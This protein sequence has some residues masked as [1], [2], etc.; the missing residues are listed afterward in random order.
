MNLKHNYLYLLV[1]LG[2]AI[3]ANTN[4]SFILEYSTSN[5]THIDFSIGEFNLSDN[6]GYTK[7][8]IPGG[9]GIISEK[10]MPEVP[11]ITTMCGTKADKDYEVSVEIV[12]SYT[13]DDINLIPFQGKSYNSEQFH[14]NEEFYKSDTQYPE[15]I[16]IT[17]NPKTFREM[18]VIS[19]GIAPFSYNPTTKVLE[20]YEEIKIIISETDKTDPIQI[21]NRP[22]SKVFTK[23]LNG[24]SINQL[25]RE[26]DEEFQEPAILYIGNNDIIDNIYFQLLKDWRHKSGYTVYTESTENIGSTTEDIKNYISDAYETF[27]PPPEYVCF[28]GDTGGSFD[29]PTYYEEFG[30]NDYDNWC[31]GDQPYSLLQGNDM[32]PEV[33]LGRISIRSIT[34]LAVI[35]SKIINYEKATDFNQNIEYYNR[36]ALVADPQESGMSTIITNEYI[37]EIMGNNGLTDINTNYDD[38]NYQ[39]WMTNQ[40]SNGVLYFNYRGFYGV[41]GFTN[42]NIDDANNGFKLPL[43]TVLTCGTGSFAEDYTCLS[44]KFLRAGTPTN[45]KGAVASVATATSNT[46]TMFNN[47]INMGIYDGIF[48]KNLNTAGAS[49]VNG[50]LSLFNT[51]PHDPNNWVSAFSHWNTLMGDPATSLWK[52]TPLKLFTDHN[53]TISLGS[54]YFEIIVVDDNGQP[55]ENARV[56]LLKGDDE[57]FLNIYTNSQGI[58]QTQLEYETIGTISVTVTKPNFQPYE[59]EVTINSPSK[60]IN[61]DEES[62]IIILDND[63]GILNPNETANIQISLYN[64]GTEPVD[65]VFGTISS[66][67][68]FLTITQAVASY[69]TIE[70]GETITKSDYTITVSESATELDN[71]DIQL[72]ITDDGGNEWFANIPLTIDGC[73]LVVNNSG[74]IERNQTT[75]LSINLLNRGSILSAPITAEILYSNELLTISNNT[76]HW[77]EIAPNHFLESEDTIT[78]TASSDIINGTVITIPLRITDSNGYNQIMYYSLQVGAVTEVDPL[79]PD[80]YGYYIYDSEDTDYMLSPVYDWIEINP[81]YGGDGESL[82]MTD[83]GNGCAS[84]WCS[85]FPES[86]HFDLPFPFVFYGEEYNEITISTNGWISFG[87]SEMESFRN[88]PVPG[89]GGPPAMIAAF[90]DDL[91]TIS[92]DGTSEGNVFVYADP[93]NELVVIEWSDMKT[94]NYDHW[95]NFEIILYNNSNELLDDGDIKIQYKTVNNTSSGGYELDPPI[96]GGYCTVGIENHLGEY[97]LQYTYNNIYPQAAKTLSDEMALLITTQSPDISTIAIPQLTPEILH[98]TLEQNDS[99]E[100]QIEL[101]NAGGYGSMLNY[102]TDIYYPSTFDEVGGGP[103]ESNYFWSDSDIGSDIEFQWEDILDTGTEVTFSHNDIATEPINI[104]FEF[105]FYGRNYTECIINP[106]GWIG[107][108]EDWVDWQNYDLPRL[109]APKPAIFGFWDDLNPTNQE[110]ANGSGSVFYHS[111]ENRFVVWYKDVI[112]Y[113]YDENN[114]YDFQ[115]VLYPSGKISLNYNEMQ[116]STTSATIGIQNET[117]VIGLPVIYNDEYLQDNM[118]IKFENTTPVIDWLTFFEAEEIYS[119]E[120]SAE[121]SQSLPFQINTTGLSVQGYSAVIFVQTLDQPDVIVPVELTVLE[122]GSVGNNYEFQITNYELMPCY[123][124]PFNPS[125]TI[126]YTIPLVET[127]F[128]ASLQIFNL[129]GKLVEELVGSGSMQE[130]GYHSVVW[131]A[132]NYPSGVYFAKLVAGNYTQTQKL[133]L[134]K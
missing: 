43:A 122:Q 25:T 101:T 65:A 14:K 110:N 93:N 15:N 109:E 113:T 12:N 7:I 94:H 61:L 100:V 115:I 6:N 116:G 32:L 76:L 68:E 130:A 33:I 78:I 44:E 75:E 62:G 84:Y 72:S 106:N 70:P 48:S 82:E 99:A 87:Y 126:S 80:Q 24:F 71:A 108:G 21:G 23:I 2:V 18:Q 67:S 91:K 96:H 16:L 105:Q 85:Q 27:D 131:D 69:G 123:P 90:W 49:L 111:D 51:Y 120:L 125:T 63:N 28:I 127:N 31:E 86:E 64:F 107:F 118:T 30:H 39:N 124:N 73:L 54:N 117:G 60:N 5:E 55:V 40:L 52:N 132:S 46:H 104:G 20:V 41:S 3:Y 89:P 35:V 11:L 114:T 13:I 1:F 26:S 38:G 36:A 59:G 102:Q 134:I 22:L 77:G 47:I 10:G 95:E 79:G 50:K 42:D 129:Q 58:A 74:F 4:S 45:P 8:E 53:A 83:Y 92:W 98:L 9:V 29:I 81:E 57:I 119:G 103:D 37:E 112:H 128:N 97:G 88:Y 133:L 66:T 56:T 121:E 17:T 19:I 34:E